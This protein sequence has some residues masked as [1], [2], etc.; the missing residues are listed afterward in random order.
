MT[1]SDYSDFREAVVGYEVA[2]SAGHAKE[3]STLHSLIVGFDMQ[4]MEEAF[5]GTDIYKTNLY[6]FVRNLLEAITNTRNKLNSRYDYYHK[7]D[8]GLWD[9]IEVLYKAGKIFD[10]IEKNLLKRVQEEPT[11][12]DKKAL[13]KLNKFLGDTHRDAT[14]EEFLDDRI[15]NNL[16]PMEAERRM[17]FLIRESTDTK[18]KRRLIIIKRLC[19]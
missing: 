13:I 4:G 19:R 3:A 6:A 5:D 1:I 16:S 14:L 2:L 7:L 12:S 10:R 11:E 18:L 17:N 9:V 15:I 8:A